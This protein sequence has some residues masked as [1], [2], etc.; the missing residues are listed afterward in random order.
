MK[1]LYQCRLKCELPR[2]VD[3][4]VE[5][6]GATPKVNH[7]DKYDLPSRRAIL[8][9]VD[10]LFSLL[11]PGY[12]RQDLCHANLAYFI[13]DRIDRLFVSLRAEITK[14]LV[15]EGA[16]GGA[17][18]PPGDAEHEAE[19]IAVRFLERLPDVRAACETDVEAAYDGDPAAKSFS[20]IVFAYPGLQAIATYRLAHE[21]LLLGTPLVP[22][23]MCE[24]AHSRTGIDIHPGATIGHGFCIDHGTGIVIGETTEIGDRVQI[25]HGVTLGAF[26][27]RK[28]QA[29]RGMKRHPT[30]EDDV[31]IYPN[32]TI[33]GGETVI[34]RGS[35]IGGNVWLT[36]SVPADSTVALDAP[37]HKIIRSGKDKSRRPAAEK[38]KKE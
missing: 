3:S 25:Y 1:Q 32:A 5:S 19:E 30:I 24:T 31:T 38:Q 23:F 6:V 29:L 28:G 12:V 2:I 33:L 37:P 17:G 7:I 35:V 36:Q 18:L 4:L 10:D 11:F 14:A 27:P 21:L 15:H 22:R 20:E 16:T 9:I 26:S 34:G 13:G 8:A